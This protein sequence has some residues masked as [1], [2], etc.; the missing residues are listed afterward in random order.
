ML[1]R[2]TRFI[3]N[4]N[5][6]T[7]IVHLAALS[8]SKHFMECETL[9]RKK[10]VRSLY[11]SSRGGKNIPPPESETM[12][13]ASSRFPAGKITRRPRSALIFAFTLSIAG[14]QV[15]CQM[16]RAVFFFSLTMTFCE[17]KC[18]RFLPTRHRGS[19]YRYWRAVR[20]FGILSAFPTSVGYRFSECE[21]APCGKSETHRC[22][23]TMNFATTVM[24]K[25]NLG[26]KT[27]LLLLFGIS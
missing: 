1:E 10:C 26:S 24:H 19:V 15:W 23:E 18:L 5:A 25:T 17:K 4:C 20:C 12:P 16:K 7:Y 3:P 2:Q 8:M 11:I 14:I 13:H 27:L 21:V 6:S 22:Y 9:R